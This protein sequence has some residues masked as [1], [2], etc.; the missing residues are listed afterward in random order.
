MT[1]RVMPPPSGPNYMKANGRDYS[2]ALGASI[3][4]PDQDGFV[5]IANGWTA[6]ASCVGTTA[7]RPAKP[8][9][10][11]DYHDTTLGKNIRSDGVTWRDPAT[12]AS[13]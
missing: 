10:G 13:V 11:Q 5:L 3:D 6:S 7:Q 1:M 12:G 2:C 9:R 4:V 8:M